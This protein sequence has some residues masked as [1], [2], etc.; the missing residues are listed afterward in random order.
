MLVPIQEI[1]AQANI[2]ERFVEPRGRYGAKIRLEYLDEPT[3]RPPAKMILVTAITPTSHGEG[4]TVTSIG[5]TQ[6]IRKLGRTAAVSL[7]QPSLGPVFGIKG[8]ANG[9]GRSQVL[10]AELVNLHFHGDFHAVTSAHNLLAAMVDNHLFHESDPRIDPAAVSWPRTMDMNDRALRRIVTGV[11]PK[12]KTME[13]ETG[14]VITAASE[15]MA[16]LALAASHADLRHR[17]EKLVVG[18]DTGGHPLRA[19]DLRATG[20]MMVLLHDA[21]LPNLVQTTEQAPAFVHAGPFGNIAHGTSS[22][23]AQKMALR[24]AEFAV[25]ECGFAADLGAEK[26]VDIVMRSSGI[27]PAGAVLVASVRALEAHGTAPDALRSGLCNLAHHAGILRTLGVPFVVGINRFP[28]DTDAEVALVRDW[29][30]DNGMECEA[31]DVFGRGGEGGVELAAKAVAL[32]ER[33]TA[34]PAPVYAETDPLE[35][36]IEAV[37]RRIYGA[38]GVEFTEKARRKI[39]RY[40]EAGY[41]ALPV[42]M[43]KTQSSTTDDPKRSGAPRGWTLRVTDADLSAGAGFVVAIAGNMMRMPGLGKEPRAVELDLDRLSSV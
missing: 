28:D 8:G 19:R 43:A 40:T 11:D 30:R 25:N 14:F 41:G 32:A 7:R 31:A 1:A 21:I 39:A 12:S 6:A 3:S 29:C 42:C 9:G 36:K 16:V 33:G 38:D 4:K 27:A 15:V 13:R 24:T 17:L 22:V 10:P 37:A 34:K 35:V 23:L 2:P 18:F 26:Y 20:S 5:L